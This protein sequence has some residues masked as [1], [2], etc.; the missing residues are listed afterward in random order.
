MDLDS[1][2]LQETSNEV[3]TTAY[4][5]MFSSENFVVY[6]SQLDSK[7]C[8]VKY[9]KTDLKNYEKYTSKKTFFPNFG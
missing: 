3:A 5:R 6:R 4:R 9:I 7:I 1:I 2:C 8:G